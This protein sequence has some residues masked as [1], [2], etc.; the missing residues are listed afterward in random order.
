MIPAGSMRTHVPTSRNL[1]AA[2]RGA[3]GI[4]VLLATVASACKKDDK[5]TYGE[6]IVDAYDRGKAN[7]ARGDLQTIAIAITSYVTNEGSLPEADDIDG[8]AAQLEPDQV[9]RCPRKDPWGTPYYYERDGESYTLA[10]AGHDKTWDTDDDLE[11]S[12]GQMTKLPKGFT[13]LQ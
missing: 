7:G 13:Q 12:D 2:T 1:G 10:S 4:A 11:L 6:R 9:R 5:P 8:L 3:L